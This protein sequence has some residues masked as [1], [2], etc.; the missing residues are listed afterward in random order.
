M[1]LQ[2]LVE[3]HRFSVVVANA[4]LGYGRRRLFHDGDSIDIHTA[5]SLHRRGALIEG[6]DGYLR[7]R[8]LERYLRDFCGYIPGGG[9][10]DTLT[11]DLGVHAVGAAVRAG[12]A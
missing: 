3:R 7:S 11:V 8:H 9:S 1:S 6:G 4:S 12:R 10:Q 5:S 2:R